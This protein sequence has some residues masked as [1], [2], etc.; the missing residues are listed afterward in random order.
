MNH[1]PNFNSDFDRDFD[2]AFTRTRRLAVGA[3][4]FNTVL[5][6]A[7]LGSIAFVVYK[8]LAHFGVL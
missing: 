8:L 4:I 2:K 5:G 6:L 3:V 7:A 1:R